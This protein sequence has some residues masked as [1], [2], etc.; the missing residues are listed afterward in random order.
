[1]YKV[2]LFFLFANDDAKKVNKYQQNGKKMILFLF[3]I[4]Y[5]NIL[6]RFFEKMFK[7]NINEKKTA[8]NI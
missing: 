3:S 6:S 2:Y 8:K 7:E 1:M 5:C 4:C